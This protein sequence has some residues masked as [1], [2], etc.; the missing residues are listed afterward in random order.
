MQSTIELRSAVSALVL[1]VAALPAVSFAQP[2]TPPQQPSAEV[3][4]S[5][6]GPWNGMRRNTDQQQ[7]PPAEQAPVSTVNDRRFPPA[8][9]AKL[10]PK[11]KAAYLKFKDLASKVVDKEPPTPDNNCLPF[12]MPGEWVSTGWPMIFFMTPKTIGIRMQIDNQVRLIHMNQEHPKNLKPTM[13]GH[14]IGWWEGDT[15]VVDS[16][17]FDERA[18]FNDGFIHGP[19][20]HVVERYRVVDGGKTLEKSFT[21]TDPES[22]T[23]PYTFTAREFLSDEPLQEY[24]NAQNNQLFPCPNEK[25]GSKYRP[26]Q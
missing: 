25:E 23:E 11:A 24:V 15:L 14:S 20:L 10:T 13:H 21:Y 17:G 7:Q 12:A 1:A 18:Q 19:D 16:I 3:M 22:L 4:R 26:V 2:S 8:L 5:F 9:E 6:I